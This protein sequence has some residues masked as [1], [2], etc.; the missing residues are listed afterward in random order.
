MIF[1]Y[2]TC[3]NKEEAEGISLSLI[4]KRLAACVNIFPLIKSIFRW[5]GKI[6]EKSEAVLIV[7]TIK[8]NFSKVEKEVKKL[9]G[10]T[11]PCILE[12]PIARA[13]QD[14]LNWLKEEIKWGKT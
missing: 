12:I 6:E 4:K 2:I 13:N 10:F 9:S 3:K 1:I 5:K 11:T 14:F 8:N 7:K